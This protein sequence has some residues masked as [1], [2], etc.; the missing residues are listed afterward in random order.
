MLVRLFIHRERRAGSAREFAVADVAQDCEQ[1]RLDRRA[2]IRVEM[3]QRAQIAFLRCI[4]G[5]GGVA[6]QIS[7]KRVDIVEMGQRGIAKT[8]RLV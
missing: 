8:L 5:I 7:R 2:T 4:V 6:E 1:P 3:A